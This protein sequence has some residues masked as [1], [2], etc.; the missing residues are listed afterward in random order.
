MGTRTLQE[1]ETQAMDVAEEACADRG[2]QVCCRKHDAVLLPTRELRA[3]IE[4]A[5]HGHLGLR[6]TLKNKTWGPTELVPSPTGPGSSAQR[7]PTS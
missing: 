7:I 6:I 5:I 1:L 3:A 4:S 2:I